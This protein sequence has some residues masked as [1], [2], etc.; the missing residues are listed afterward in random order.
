MLLR[1]FIAFFNSNLDQWS[2]TNPLGKMQYGRE[3]LLMLQQQ[4][5]SRKK[6]EGLPDLEVIVVSD[7]QILFF[8]MYFKCVISNFEKLP[9]IQATNKPRY[10]RNSS[11]MFQK[12]MSGSQGS[13]PDFIPNYLSNNSRVSFFTSCLR[14]A[15]QKFL[16]FGEH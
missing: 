16:N 7:A 13:V 15:T 3:F 14:K 1:L 9:I 4:P 11:N 2:P 6:P 5:M 10:D 8:R 12:S